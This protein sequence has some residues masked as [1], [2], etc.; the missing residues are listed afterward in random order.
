[1]SKYTCLADGSWTSP[2]ES[3][4][5]IQCQSG[6]IEI[7]DMNADNTGIKIGQ[8]DMIAFS[9][10]VYVR[11]TNKKQAVY[12]AV[13]FDVTGGGGGGGGGGSYTLPTASATVKGGIKVGDRLSIN[14]QGVLSADSQ[15]SDWTSGKQ[16]KVGDTVLIN[17]RF[18][19]CKTNHTS[20]SPINMLD[21]Y[22]IYTDIPDWSANTDYEAGNVVIYNDTLYQCNTAHTSGSTFDT[23][24]FTS[25]GG[26][27][28]DAK[29]TEA[30]TANTAAGA[31]KV[32]DVVAKDTTFTQFVK[33]LLISEIAPTVTFTAT[34]SG[35][36]K[37]GNS[38]TSTTL[39]LV[40]NS[41][42]TGT[43][44]SIEFFEGTTSLDTQNYVAG[45]TTYT[46]A[47]TPTNPI[48][49]N[50]TFKAVLKYKK[51]DGTVTTLTKEVKFTFVDP[52]YYGAVSAPP[53]TEADVL[54]VGNETVTDKCDRTVTYTLNNQKSCYCYPVS[55]GALT[56][57]K[58]ANNFEYLGSYDRTTV[59]VTVVVDGVSSTVNYY[60]YTLHDP[61]TITGF[62]QIFKK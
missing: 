47:Y 33:Q 19:K 55:L 39:K 54:A 14:N 25:I 36:I 51:S 45:T 53:T 7:C 4:G 52:V 16:Y 9:G 37:K 22:G 34:G 2:S 31:I 61:V 58:D 27:G 21:W 48:F 29:L 23:N 42:G 17:G 59:P 60:V 43:Y 26:G 57:I 62:K 35:L 10:T 1:M 46:Y 8:G 18:Y 56:S 38:V 49:T 15:T 13:P 30:V 3:A 11:S 24:K 44:V 32:N 6:Q 20:S 50:T 40:L 41:A 28:G 5:S 12:T